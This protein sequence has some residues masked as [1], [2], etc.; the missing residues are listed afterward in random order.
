M[1]INVRQ[2][3]D[4]KNKTDVEAILQNLII[5]LGIIHFNRKFSH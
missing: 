4:K 2:I 5:S 3:S 1:L